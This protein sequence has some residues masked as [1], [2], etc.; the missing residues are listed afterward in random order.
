[1]TDREESTKI[2]Y[3]GPPGRGFGFELAGIETHAST[4]GVMMLEL[5]KELARA[6]DVGIIFIDEGL[7]LQVLDELEAMNRQSLPALVLLPNPA[8]PQRTAAQRLE[9]LMVTAVGSDIF[10]D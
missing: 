8:N 1:M 7:A 3:I 10:N 4:S 2:T 5:V 9:K 6:G